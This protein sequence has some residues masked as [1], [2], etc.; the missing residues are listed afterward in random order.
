[1][2]INPKQYTIMRFS[3]FTLIL[4]LTSSSTLIAQET[5]VGNNFYSDKTA[6]YRHWL[7]S[8]NLSRYIS[9]DT[10]MLDGKDL[11]LNL[12]SSVW[13]SLESA[14]N[15]KFSTSLINYLFDKAVFIFDSTPEET[16][17]EIDAGKNSIFIDSEE[18]ELK[19]EKLKKQGVVVGNVKVN[20][21]DL[22]ISNMG[23]AYTQESLD[24]VIAKLKKGLDN[25]YKDHA[26]K[27]VEKYVFESYNTEDGNL[28]VEARNIVDEVLNKGYF[29]KI[30]IN[31]T[32]T[33]KGKQL[34]VDY[35][36]DCKYASGILWA[37][38]S[39][40]WKDIGSDYKAEMDKYTLKMKAV[41]NEILKK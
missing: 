13:D 32:F 28:Y 10:I 4:F 2:F 9:C 14:F 16:H 37:P 39:S 25:H 15:K 22:K 18:S 35:T 6:E 31:F 23:S 40:G 21:A 34:A 30:V 36:I 29:E 27:L 20:I 19:I 24:K 33:E 26:P 8:S 11:T 41:I 7:S 17:L 12:K 5:G 38:K 3:L 1:M